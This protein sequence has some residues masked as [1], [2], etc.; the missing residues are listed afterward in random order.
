MVD[1]QPVVFNKLASRPS[2]IGKRAEAAFVV[3]VGVADGKVTHE[4]I[5]WDQASM[6]VQIGLLNPT[7]LPVSGAQQARLVLDPT[8][9]HRRGY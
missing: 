4:H 6:L 3:I 9:E 5:Y 7:G 1:P 2:T 8:L